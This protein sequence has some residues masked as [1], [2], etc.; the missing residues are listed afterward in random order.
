MLR[1]QAQLL[2]NSGSSRICQG[3]VLH[4]IVPG[5]VV[6]SGSDF[7]ADCRVGWRM[8]MQNTKLYRLQRVR[9]NTIMS[10]TVF[11]LLCLK[12]RLI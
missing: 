7:E 4:F 6:G 11:S 10:E 9:R 8:K 12:S 3:K 5:V 2:N 1:Q